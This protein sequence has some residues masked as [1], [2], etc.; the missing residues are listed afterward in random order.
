MA[1]PTYVPLATYTVT[2]SAAASVT[3]S[4]IPAG[5]RDLILVVDG[6][7]DSE[8]TVGLRF[9]GDSGANYSYV[10]GLGYSSGVLSIAGTSEAAAVGRIASTQTNTIVNIMDYGQTDKHKTTLSRTNNAGSSTR[11]SATRWA[12]TDAIYSIEVMQAT[13]N[14]GTTFSLYGVN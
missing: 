12:N 7:A 4:S 1:T 6:T 11:M 14:V 3:F 10:Q 13:Y 8:N 2:G 5:Y 9:N